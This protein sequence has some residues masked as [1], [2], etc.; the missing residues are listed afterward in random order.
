MALEFCSARDYRV[1]PR[2]CASKL[3]TFAAPSGRRSHGPTSKLSRLFLQ[4][5][6]IQAV[7]SSLRLTGQGLIVRETIHPMEVDTGITLEE[8]FYL[9]G[10]ISRAGF[11]FLAQ[12]PICTLPHVNP[13]TWSWSAN[14]GR[15]A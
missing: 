2:P 13:G 8:I 15:L 3:T 10:R 11:A 12:C 6:L 5:I 4:S 7:L 1:W 9:K 14:A